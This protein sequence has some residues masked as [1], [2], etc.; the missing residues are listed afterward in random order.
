MAV[1]KLSFVS[2]CAWNPLSLV[3]MGVWKPSETLLT[4]LKSL[5]DLVLASFKA[6][7]TLW[8][9]GAGYHTTAKMSMAPRHKYPDPHKVTPR[10]LT[11]W[12]LPPSGSSWYIR[13]KV[14][15]RLS[16]DR[17]LPLSSYTKGLWK[18]LYLPV[19]KA[20]ENISI[21]HSLMSTLSPPHLGAWHKP[22][23]AL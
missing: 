2:W 19:E 10:T 17:R 16:Q 6:S 18:T 12:T 4:P 23:K 22:S 14:F 7:E 21:L 5:W 3:L 8:S 11:I 15:H 13:P 1:L 9:K 20:V